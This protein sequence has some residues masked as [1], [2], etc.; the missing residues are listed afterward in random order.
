MQK[1]I[2]KKE[3]NDILYPELIQIEIKKKKKNNE[4]VFRYQSGNETII[5]P[6]DVKEP[7]GVS[8][9]ALVYIMIGL[10][11]GVAMALSLILP[12]MQ[13]S[14]WVIPKTILVRPTPIS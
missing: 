5:Q 2:F 10:G 6:L 11:I 3:S 9:S 7:K 14:H 4:E 13:N 12:A 8:L 1:T